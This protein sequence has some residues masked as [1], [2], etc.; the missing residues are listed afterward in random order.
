MYKMKIHATTLTLIKS[1]TLR[2][3]TG[4]LLTS[5]ETERLEELALTLWEVLDLS[6]TTARKV[7]KKMIRWAED[8]SE[9][10]LWHP[11]Q[12]ASYLS[13]ICGESPPAIDNYERFARRLCEFLEPLGDE[14]IEKNALV[15]SSL[16]NSI[17]SRGE[18]LESNQ[19]TL[20]NILI[21]LGEYYPI[22]FVQSE[23]TLLVFFTHD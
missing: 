15:I 4:D 20:R 6:T 1:I 22:R 12:A 8:I 13:M 17:V 9:Q 23:T 7:C 10:V 14:S 21:D 11:I 2:M 16:H 18:I 19:E 3:H 5:E